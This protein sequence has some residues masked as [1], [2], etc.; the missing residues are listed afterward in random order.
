[1]DKVLIIDGYNMFIR[2]YVVNPSL[3]P[4]GDPI[5]G[6]FGFLKSLQKLI[7]QSKPTQVIVAWDG[8]GGSRKRKEMVKT[9]KEGRK[10]LQLNRNVPQN[11]T[12][13]ELMQNRYD[14][15][16]RL[17]EYLNDMPVIQLLIEDVEADDII[18][19]VVRMPSLRGKVK[20]IVSSDRDFFQLCDDE[21]VVLRPIQDKVVN[22]K[23]LLEEFGIHPNNFALARAITGDKSDNLEGIKGAGLP[24]VA[25]RFPFLAESKSCTVK[26]LLKYCK[27]T[28]NKSQLY[29]RVLDGKEV[30]KLN[31]KMMQL[32]QP[33][34]SAANARYVR[35][36]I[37]DF[38]PTFHQTNTTKRMLE[39]GFVEYNWDNLFQN[40]RRIVTSSKT[41]KN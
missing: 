14:Q 32:Y 25:K 41:A 34:I 2:N 26:D 22:E 29:S 3:S 30:I 10:P 31:Y 23:R 24:T 7:R 39:D 38:S 17:V 16:L 6:T 33:I 19:Q 5:G 20:V 9:Y 4:Q 37:D 40:F 36:T 12:A 18:A 35:N 8:D 13:D 1:M 27:T 15:F 21:T 11:L 28:E